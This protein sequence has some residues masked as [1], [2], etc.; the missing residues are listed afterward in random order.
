M[1]AS[2]HE[3]DGNAFPGI[4]RS[5]H[6]SITASLRSRSE[7]DPEVQASPITPV[8]MAVEGAVL[9]ELLWMG[10]AVQYPD[11]RNTPVTGDG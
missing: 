3:Q 6:P 2:F 11:L 4:V 8:L 1:A 5:R 10:K 9:G 7:N